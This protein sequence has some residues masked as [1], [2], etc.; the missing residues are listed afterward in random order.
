MTAV[1]PPEVETPELIKAKITSET[2]RINWLELQKFYAAGSVVAVDV[3]LDL[4]DVAFA[5]SQDDSAQVQSWLEQGS[6]ARVSEPQAQQ[7]FDAKQELWAVVISPWVL[8]QDKPTS[9][10][11]N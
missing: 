2:A 8:V 6:V 3:A 7:W 10:Q 9:A 4:V 5:F 11:L 1:T